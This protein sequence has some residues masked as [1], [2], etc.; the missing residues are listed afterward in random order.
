M[1]VYLLKNGGWTD[2]DCWSVEYYPNKQMPKYKYTEIRQLDNGLG[3]N[4]NESGK[5]NFSPMKIFLSFAALLTLLIALINQLVGD[6]IMITV[7]L[8]WASH[9]L[10]YVEGNSK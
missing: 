8:L 1:V 7:I 6:N 9:F 4:N 3:L 2:K 10:K 5:T